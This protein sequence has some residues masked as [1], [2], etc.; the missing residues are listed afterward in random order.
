MP[1][2]KSVMAYINLILSM[3][4]YKGYAPNT[5]TLYDFKYSWD[6]CIQTGL[7][8]GQQPFFKPFSIY[9]LNIFL[10]VGKR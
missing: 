1:L 8:N 9:R 4:L 7:Y 10:S 5:L 6:I 3:G 2:Q